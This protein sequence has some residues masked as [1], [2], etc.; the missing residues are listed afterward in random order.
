MR[1]NQEHLTWHGPFTFRALL[2]DGSLLSRFQLPRV[3]LWVDRNFTRLWYV[4]R[5]FSNLDVRTIYVAIAATCFKVAAG[6]FASQ[7]R[8]LW[9]DGALQW[10]LSWAFQGAFWVLLG[11]RAIWRWVLG[12]VTPNHPV[13][14]PAAPESG[15]AALIKHCSAKGPYFN[16]IFPRQRKANDREDLRAF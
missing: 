12:E 5:S 9:R 8:R 2:T 13:N 14:V 1:M 11:L 15:V 3:Y 4:G 6:L 7:A 10:T 16:G